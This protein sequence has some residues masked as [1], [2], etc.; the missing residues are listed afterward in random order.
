MGRL[1]DLVGQAKIL[2]KGDDLWRA[3]VALESAILEL[4]LR[5]RLEH[6]QPPPPPKRTAKKDDLIAQ[7]REKLGRL[8]LQGDRKKLLYD[9][10][11]CRD[12]LKAALAKT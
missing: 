4:K 1:D 7:A 8:D 3:Y 12:A 9:L 6:E 11:V 2:G 5:H 10:R